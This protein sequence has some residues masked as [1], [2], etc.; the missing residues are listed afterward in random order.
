M[1][2]ARR[3]TAAAATLVLLAAA[4]SGQAAGPTTPSAVSTAFVQGYL[5]ADP[6]VCDLATP[7][8]QQLFARLAKGSTCKAALGAARAEGDAAADK[9]ARRALRDTVQA[10]QVLIDAR[11]N[12]TGKRRLWLVPHS[13]VA[14]LVANMRAHDIEVRVGRGPSSARGTPTGVVFVDATRTTATKLVL[15]TESTSGVIWR[16]TSSPYQIGTPTRAGRGI[17]VHPV[18]AARAFPYRAPGGSPVS[19]V[20]VTAASDQFGSISFLLTLTPQN[21]VD[22]VLLGSLV[23]PLVS[24]SGAGDTDAIAERLVRLWQQGDEKGLCAALHPSLELS[25]AMFGEK[26]S[27]A[28]DPV[29]AVRVET[30]GLAGWSADGTSI[31]AIRVSQ[32]NDSFTLHHVVTPL[33]S[34]YSVTGL[35]L[36]FD[37][38]AALL[39]RPI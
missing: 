21:R 18:P 5:T 25:H 14:A 4:T 33:A 24:G 38:L 13:R 8:I 37:E 36:D 6:A 22:A 31:V 28:S 23:T 7:R 16:L 11:A 12:A 34:G 26:C 2:A 10:T 20:A 35:F 3:W 29:T 15:Y 32:G 27:V 39:L 30:P 19:R 9:S 17:A 1:R